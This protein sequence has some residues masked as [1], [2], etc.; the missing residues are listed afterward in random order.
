MRTS[1]LDKCS[2]L[3]A[4]DG[5]NA[6][7]RPGVPRIGSCDANCANGDSPKS[8]DKFAAFP[9]DW[10]K[11]VRCQFK[12]PTSRLDPSSMQALICNIFVDNWSLASISLCVHCKCVSVWVGVKAPL[13]PGD[14]LYCDMSLDPRSDKDPA[15][16]VRRWSPGE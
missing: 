8:P 16:P 7:V 5:R 6:S 12:T 1:W 10:P 9:G 11:P 4:G 3:G 13:K 15:D 2:Y 14:A